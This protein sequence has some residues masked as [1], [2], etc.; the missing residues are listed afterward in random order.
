MTVTI[1]IYP[2]GAL[3]APQLPPAAVFFRG[4]D[5][6]PT[7]FPRTLPYR[8][9]YF[10][11]GLCLRG[12][13]RL[14]VNL[15]TYDIGPGALLVLSPYVIKQ[16]H[17]FSPDFAAF[18]LFFTREFAAGPGSLNPD[19][20]A[21]FARDARPVL[22]LLPAQAELIAAQL[23]AIGERYAEPHAY[24]TEILRSLTHI[25]L[26]ETAPIYSQQQITAPA[27][28]SRSQLI[29]AGFKQLVNAHYA[30]ERG[31]A[32]YA[33]HL[34]IT[35]KHLAESVKEATGRRAGEWLT[36][37]VLLEARVLLQNPA[38]TVAQVADAL[39]FADQST[40]GRFFRR[41]TGA[42]PA[43]YRQGRQ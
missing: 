43:A 14:S 12:Q 7:H 32:F 5:S 9:D 39:H 18:S 11:I 6:E 3:T 16:W 17:S 21:F 1:P 40:F 25:L 37:A 8:S 30:T 22:S 19:S 33:D 20:F 15:D 26:H 10:K 29:A 34:C 42:S 36:E 28:H 2:L 4:P 41:G 13:A 31:L 35:A 24:R 38:L 27:G 23:R